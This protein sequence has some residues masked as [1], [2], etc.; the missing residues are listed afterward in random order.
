MHQ[1]RFI[2]SFEL[3]YICYVEFFKSLH[4][5]VLISAYPLAMRSSELRTQCHSIIYLFLMFIFIMR[6]IASWTSGEC[7]SDFVACVQM[8]TSAF[9][10]PCHSTLMTYPTTGSSVWTCYK[11][12]SLE[13]LEK[14][15]SVPWHFYS[16]SLFKIIIF[17]VI[18]FIYLIGRNMRCLVNKHTR[19]TQTAGV[20]PV[21][22]EQHECPLNTCKIVIDFTKPDNFI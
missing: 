14:S 6:Y 2:T 1:R 7:F 16:E 19:C 11:D 20:W 9:S 13:R 8:T 3:S 15:W 5:V 22:C 17:F 18:L 12:S 21:T 4:N 10:S